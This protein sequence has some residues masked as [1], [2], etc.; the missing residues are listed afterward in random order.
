MLAVAWVAPG[1]QIVMV[2]VTWA[3]VVVVVVV[4]VDI[5]LYYFGM[6][7]GIQAAVQVGMVVMGL[8]TSFNQAL[9][10]MVQ[11]VGEVAEVQVAVTTVMVM[12]LLPALAAAALVYLDKGIVVFGVQQY[13]QT[14]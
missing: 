8:G 6:V 4:L 10:R 13:C 7:C 9:E 5:V 12:E 11:V 2:L 3:V 14:S 1:V